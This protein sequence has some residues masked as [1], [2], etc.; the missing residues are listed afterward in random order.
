MVSPS[1]VPEALC[2]ER[3]HWGYKAIEGSEDLKEE[4]CTK[5]FVL[6]TR[7]RNSGAVQTVHR[8]YVADGKYLCDLFTH[9]L[10]NKKTSREREPYKQSVPKF[11]RVHPVDLAPAGLEYDWDS[12]FTSRDACIKTRMKEYQVRSSSGRG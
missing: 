7:K 1:V 12:F 6:Y 3:R 11:H 5:A 8:L 4:L 9:S 10:V 2:F